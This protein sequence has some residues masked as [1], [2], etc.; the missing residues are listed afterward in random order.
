M[1]IVMK[2]SNFNWN[3][4]FSYIVNPVNCVG[5][6]GAGFALEV[7]NRF[8]E[9][10]AQYKQECKMKRLMLG[11]FYING[12]VIF[13]PT[14]NHWKDRVTSFKTSYKDILE[15]P[16]TK[17]VD[18]KSE[19]FVNYSIYSSLK[20]LERHFMTSSA[21]IK[22]G[23]PLLGCG[24]AGGRPESFIEMMR[25]EFDENSRIVY[26]IYDNSGN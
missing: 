7:K 19:A 17:L 15:T 10:E 1:V 14:K 9:A 5:V 20:K 21:I 16:N 4:K 8:P 23:M 12:S 11:Y 3:E 2:N 22:I 26:Q 6:S 24:L 25:T 13:L 18:L